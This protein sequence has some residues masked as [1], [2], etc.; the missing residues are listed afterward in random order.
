M[1]LAELFGEQPRKAKKAQ[2]LVESKVAVLAAK[3]LVKP[4]QKKGR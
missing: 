1:T 2:A 3:R 4:V